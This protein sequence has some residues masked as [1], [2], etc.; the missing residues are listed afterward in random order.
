M[1]T[2]LSLA[3]Q[4]YFVIPHLPLYQ[5]VNQLVQV[6]QSTHKSIN[7]LINVNLRC[8][9]RP[10]PPVSSSASQAP[11]HSSPAN[12]LVNQSINQSANQATSRSP[13][14]LDN[15]P[16]NQPINQL[17]NQSINQ[18]I[19][20]TI[21]QYLVVG[22]LWVNLISQSGDL[23]FTVPAVQPLD[24]HLYRPENKIPGT[25]TTFQPY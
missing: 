20:K 6:S 15:H 24:V 1:P 13:N 9:F 19:N 16:I 17:I 11:H 25:M 5:S 22:T 10:C 7:Q 8:W 21:N 3:L 2:C 12:Q 18:P 14:Q 4:A 23:K